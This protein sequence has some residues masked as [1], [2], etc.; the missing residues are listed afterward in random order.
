LVLS[1]LLL[2]CLLCSTLFRPL[3]H[4]SAKKHSA[5]KST[6][7]KESEDSGI[8][9]EEKQL[10]TIKDPD[11]PKLLLETSM[12]DKKLTK[13]NSICTANIPAHLLTTD[14]SASHNAMHKLAHAS[15]GGT[16]TGSVTLV[17]S[18]SPSL[19]GLR[20]RSSTHYKVVPSKVPGENLYSQSM[21]MLTDQSTKQSGSFYHSAGH[22]SGNIIARSAGKLH[23]SNEVLQK[24]LYRKDAFYSGSVK[25]LP[26][27]NRDP[28]RSVFT[29]SMM[30]IPDIAL[31]D[32]SN[33]SSTRL[34]CSELSYI[35]QSLMGLSL[36][37]S[38]VFLLC[39]SMSVLWT[40]HA[41][42]LGILPDFAVQQG[43]PSMYASLLLSVIGISNIIGR[44]VAGWLADMPRVSVVAL[45]AGALFVGG[46]INFMIPYTTNYSMLAAEAAIFGLC[47]AAW[48]SLRPIVIVEMLGLERLTNAFGLLAMFQGVS[49]CI[50]T[51]TAGFLFDATQSYKMPFL[52]S[53]TAFIVSSFLCLPMVICSR[54]E[55]QREEALTQ[56][57]TL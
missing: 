25:R 54:R 17:P 16:Y 13:S 14:A 51:P 37:K 36:L 2:H 43:I 38:P 35:L 21:M 4:P 27:Y 9:D 56:L 52:M 22:L 11:V 50:V 44:I 15:S 29:G 7:A 28:D 12:V 31:D 41:A 42:V 33:G 57:P 10:I 6:L 53:G 30:R 24:P 8:G 20:S 19:G 18:A 23:L 32:Q 47:M 48:T 39:V 34:D 40:S 55:K 45:N 26:E 49:F 5:K 46:V 1:A 3:T